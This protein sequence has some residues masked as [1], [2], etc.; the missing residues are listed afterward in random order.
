MDVTARGGPEVP[1]DLM[2]STVAVVDRW[3]DLEADTVPVAE[4]GTLLEG[5]DRQI[6]RLEGA[7][8]Q[9]A[10]SFSR[11]DGH[12][13]T[14]HK[15]LS[16]WMQDRLRRSPTQARKEAKTA[17]QLDG[18]S[19]TAEALG[20]GDISLEHAAVIAEQAS[21]TDD[22]QGTQR[23][24]LAEAKTAD[25][26][27][28]RKAGRRMQRDEA[29]RAE[30]ARKVRMAKQNRTLSFRADDTEK[31]MWIEGRLPMIDGV[32][33]RAALDALATPAGSDDDRT[34]GQR[35]AD[36]LIELTE[37]AEDGRG[38][39][40]RRGVP[41]EVMAVVP[42]QAIERR[43]GVPAGTITGGP[44]GGLDL[45]NAELADLLERARLSWLIV[46]PAGVPLRYGRGRRLAST[47]QRRV[48]RAR[49]GGCAW[50]RC[51]APGVWTIAHHEPPFDEPGGATDLATQALLCD[52]HH[53][54]RHDGRWD[55]QLTPDATV[56]VTSPDSQT[57][58]TETA[59]QRRARHSTWELSN[60]PPVDAARERRATYHVGLDPGE[61]N[62]MLVRRPST[63]N[64][65]R[66]GPRIPGRGPLPW[67]RLTR[68]AA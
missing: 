17:E 68:G 33:A 42:V 12:R 52:T 29:R 59:V 56:T 13:A 64:G 35:M 43:A 3:V 51:D 2:G 11:R 47:D 58:L 38:L 65:A 7:R 36:A 53:G 21:K 30:A 5:L 44:G 45:C 62:S 23:S 6:N 1:S 9:L 41:V 60:H 31:T 54:L 63:T 57:T 34:Y 4:A 16:H 19:A 26:G 20:N 39:P 40:S 14:G 32:K 61:V 49:D 66:A 15:N 28:V 18:L 37:R 27:R 25:P 55:I 8:S 50:P 46:D 67:R 48:L 10:A 22:P 24:L